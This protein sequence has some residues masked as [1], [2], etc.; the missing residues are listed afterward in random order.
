[1]EPIYAAVPQRDLAFEHEINGL[2]AVRVQG[3]RRAGL[4]VDDEVHQIGLSASVCYDEPRLG[5]DFPLS[6]YGRIPISLAEDSLS[7]RWQQPSRQRKAPRPCG[8]SVGSASGIS[9]H[10]L[11]MRIEHR[12]Q[13]DSLGRRISRISKTGQFGAFLPE[14][15]ATVFARSRSSFFKS[16]SLAR[17]SSR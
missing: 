11:Q 17:M 14:H 6:R 3:R 7:G 10:E 13:G 8:D 16:D 9:N 15:R 2:A 4:E 12:F 5:H 1:V